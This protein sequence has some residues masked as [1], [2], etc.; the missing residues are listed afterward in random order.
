MTS[1]LLVS[2]VTG[3]PCGCRG[4]ILNRML[5]LRAVARSVIHG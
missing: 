2:H 5:G 1:I 4:N 3:K